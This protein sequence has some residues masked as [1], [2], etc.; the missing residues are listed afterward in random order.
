MISIA[1]PIRVDIPMIGSK[2][3]Q[4]KKGKKLDLDSFLAPLLE[5]MLAYESVPTLKWDPTSQKLDTA[6]F[7]LRAHLL[8]VSGDM[9]GISKASRAV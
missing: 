3:H 6:A 7:T 5:R 1:I 8:S 4:G 9:P 2:V